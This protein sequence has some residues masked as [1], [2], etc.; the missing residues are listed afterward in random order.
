MLKMTIALHLLLWTAWYV[1]VN[2]YACNYASWQ[3]MCTAECH[4]PGWFCIP[5]LLAA[6]YWNKPRPVKFNVKSFSFNGSEHIHMS[7]MR[8]KR[9]HGVPVVHMSLEV[10]IQWKCKHTHHH[11]INMCCDL[12]PVGYRTWTVQLIKDSLDLN[13]ERLKLWFCLKMKLNCNYCRD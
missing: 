13:D 5:L 12:I 3:S 7:Y 1:I 11:Y 2:N 8:Y 10:Q 4:V 9:H 6:S